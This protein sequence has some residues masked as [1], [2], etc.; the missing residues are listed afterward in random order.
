MKHAMPALTLI[1]SVL[2]PLTSHAVMTEA[3]VSQFANAMTVAANAKNVNLV[4]NLIDDKA[5]ISISRKGQTGTLDKSA[6]LN[7][8]QSNWT[9]SSNYHY[10][11]EI[12]NVLITGSQAK[13]DITTTETLT[14]KGKTL[15][16]ITQSR[17][18]FYETPT[19]ATLGRAISQLTIQ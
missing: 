3:K 15:T 13:A 8:L 14:E 16:L 17:A 5:L 7:L 10:R 1:L 4:A 18:T 9:K 19:G 2:L 12:H 6:Y 11:I